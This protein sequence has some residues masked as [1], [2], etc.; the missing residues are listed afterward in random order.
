M[1]SFFKLRTTQ[2]LHYASQNKEIRLHTE[3]HLKSYF[4]GALCVWK[5][6]SQPAATCALQLSSRVPP[7]CILR[8]SLRGLS[9]NVGV[10]G[11]FPVPFGLIWI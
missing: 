8:A 4:C 5:S 11:D 7:L 2:N 10:D 3:F 1:T 6:N 9:P